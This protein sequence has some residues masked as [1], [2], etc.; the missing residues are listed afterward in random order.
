MP[1]FG[2]TLTEEQLASVVAFERVRF[3]GGNPDE[4]LADCGLVEAGG[5][6]GE[7]EAPAEGGEGE[8]PAE[9]GEGEAP[10][11]TTVPSEASAG[12]NG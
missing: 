6:G 7:G 3:G 1:G 4:V 5:E 2:G 11:G 9:G 8:A 12:G 10:T